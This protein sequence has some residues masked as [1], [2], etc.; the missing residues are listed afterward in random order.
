MFMIRISE[1][2]TL[3]NN[4][5]HMI[6]D[7]TW[8]MFVLGSQKSV[9]VDSIALNQLLTNAIQHLRIYDEG[10]INQQDR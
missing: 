7:E 4:T 8:S 5:G 2:P 3:I 1:P 9:S 6:A 10:L